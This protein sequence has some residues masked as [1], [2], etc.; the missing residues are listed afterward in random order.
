MARPGTEY[1]IDVVEIEK[2]ARRLRAEW[3][4]GAFGRLRRR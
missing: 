2:E 4:K 3:L 1:L